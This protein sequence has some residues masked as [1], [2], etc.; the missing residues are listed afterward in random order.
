MTIKKSADAT[1]SALAVAHGSTALSFDHPSFAS[2]TTTYYLSVANTV[3]TLKV[4]PTKNDSNAGVAYFDED[5]MAITDTDTS[6]ANA[7]DAALDVGPNTIKV[8]VTA[9]NGSTTETYTLHVGRAAL[10]P[11]GA[12]DGI[13][14]ANLTLGWEEGGDTL[15][16]RF[17]RLQHRDVRDQ[18]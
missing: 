10:A 4:T 5:D 11:T 7:L 14:C 6:S 9:E 17:L 1:L 8:K 12:C 15:I 13:W 18:Q 3:S 2:D 16:T